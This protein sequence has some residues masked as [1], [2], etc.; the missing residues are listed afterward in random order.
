MK[1]LKYLSDVRKLGK[2]SRQHIFILQVRWK[3]NEDYFLPHHKGHIQ[4]KEN[5][6]K[7]NLLSDLFNWFMPRAIL[8][9]KSY[10]IYTH[11]IYI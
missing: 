10:V 4:K 2:G 8:I 9:F 1:H 6:G 7:L 11:W 3:Y 5:R